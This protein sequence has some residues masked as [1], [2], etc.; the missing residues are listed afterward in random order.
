MAEKLLVFFDINIILD[1]L[2]KRIPFYEASASLLAA[3]ETGRI[4]G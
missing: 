3:A 2:Q 1:V 4:Q